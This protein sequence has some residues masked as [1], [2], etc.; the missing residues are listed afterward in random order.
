M[1][2][3][4]GIHNPAPPGRSVRAPGGAGGARPGE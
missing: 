4:G 2:A 1:G 3:P